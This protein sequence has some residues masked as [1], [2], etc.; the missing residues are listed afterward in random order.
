MPRTAKVADNSVPAEA[1][2]DQSFWR[3]KYN[4]TFEPGANGLFHFYDGSLQAHDG[5]I[6]VPRDRPEWAQRLLRFEHF[7]WPE[8]ETPEAFMVAMGFGL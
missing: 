2:T 6:D 3:L 5:F 8:G 4:G 7:V 1:G